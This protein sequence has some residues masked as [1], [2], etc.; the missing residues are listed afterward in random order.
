MGF[1]SRKGNLTKGLQDFS[2][3]GTLMR[4]NHLVELEIWIQLVWLE[5]L[6]LI[7]N[8]IPQDAYAAGLRAMR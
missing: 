6:F 4:R 5:L 7:S 8:N 2:F 1:K 3:F